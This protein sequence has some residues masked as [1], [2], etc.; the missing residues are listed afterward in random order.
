MNRKELLQPAHWPALTLRMLRA[1]R[2]ELAAV[3][4]LLVLGVG[5]L[6]FMEIADDVGEGDTKGIDMS[7]LM[8]FREPGDPL[9]P[10]GGRWVREAVGDITALG[11]WTVL[12]LFVLFLV[13]FLLS[14]KRWREALVLLVAAMGGTALGQTLKG[15]FGRERPD[16]AWRLV[17]VANASFPSGHAMMSAVVYLT[18]GALVARFAN[19]TRVKLFAMTVGV[20]LTAMVGVSRVYLGAHWP[21]DVLAG[22]CVGAAWA[23]ACWLASWAA[24]KW[25][26]RDVDE[27]TEG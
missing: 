12:T 19:R 2:A 3:G 26:G 18:L 4:A 13:G 17:E 23:M 14:L 8:M 9:T 20:I 24:E 15:V 21:S 1:A 6:S 5:V 10:I 7:I 25:W 16:E 27:R 22:W 11:G